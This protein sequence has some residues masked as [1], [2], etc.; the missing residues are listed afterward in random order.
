MKKLWNDEV[1]AVTFSGS[2]LESNVNVRGKLKFYDGNRNE[3]RPSSIWQYSI[4]PP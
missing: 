4:A 3:K 2:I 1:P